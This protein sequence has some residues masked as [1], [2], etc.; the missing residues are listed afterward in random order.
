MFFE[1]AMLTLFTAFLDAFCEPHTGMYFDILGE[2]TEEKQK[3]E[4]F[5][6]ILD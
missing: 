4:N 1:I 6:E 2:Y 3:A 5:R